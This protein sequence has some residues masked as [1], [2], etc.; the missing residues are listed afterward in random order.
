MAR[1]HAM[2][3]GTHAILLHVRRRRLL[4]FRTLFHD[5]EVHTL[6]ECPLLTGRPPNRVMK[7]ESARSLHWQFAVVRI[8][9]FAQEDSK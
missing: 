7:V 2:T 3:T 8:V 1:V 4:W 6:V 5:C 9:H